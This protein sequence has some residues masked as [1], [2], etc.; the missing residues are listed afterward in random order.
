MVATTDVPVILEPAMS[1]TPPP[2]P[3]QEPTPQPA[4]SGDSG[5]STG[6]EPNVAALLTYVLGLVTGIIFY[7]IEK[8][9]VE[10]RFHAAQSI[11][12]SIAAIALSVLVGILSAIPFL[13]WLFWMLGSLISLGFFVLWVFLLIKAYQLEHFKLPVIGDMAED[14]AK[15]GI[16]TA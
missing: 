8:R 4:G 14:W 13:G 15:Q 11:L 12:V 2:P 6:L 1:E 9:H 5:T 7:V 10:V 3:P 16:D